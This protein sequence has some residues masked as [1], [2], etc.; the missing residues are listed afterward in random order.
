MTFDPN[1]VRVDI[2]ELGRRIP[3][4]IWVWPDSPSS[5]AFTR[6]GKRFVGYG[7]SPYAAYLEAKALRDRQL[8]ALVPSSSLPPG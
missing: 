3:I 5:D 6:D 4:D 2:D 1:R 7:C 8:P